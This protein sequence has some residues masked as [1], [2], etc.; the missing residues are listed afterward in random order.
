LNALR[1]GRTAI[2]VALPFLGACV[3]DDASSNAPIIDAQRCEVQIIM[4]YA[5]VPATEPDT[6]LMADLGSKAQV[7]LHYLRSIVAGTDVLTLNADDPDPRCS[8][9]LERLRA[10]PRV[11]SVSIDERRALDRSSF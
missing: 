5:A 6:A 7:E 3:T 9:A 8:H 11:R 10:D 4:T 1:I 2:V